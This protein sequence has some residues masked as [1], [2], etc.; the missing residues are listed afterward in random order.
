MSNFK[1]LFPKDKPVII[2]FPPFLQQQVFRWIKSHVASHTPR[3][4]VHNY[5]YTALKDSFNAQI[6]AEF[7]TD[8]GSTL[9][10]HFESISGNR[11]MIAEYINYLLQHYTDEQ[12][13]A[14]LERILAAANSEFSVNIRKIDLDRPHLSEPD[15]FI[16]P[17]YKIAT[18][19]EFRAEEETRKQ[20]DITNSE[21]LKDAWSDFYSVSN[22]N[23]N[24]VTQKSL[25]VVAGAIRD[26]L[27]SADQKTNLSDYARRIERDI[28]RLDL[29]N[30]E[31]VDWVSIIKSLANH[32]DARGVHNSG[33]DTDATEDQAYT[34]LHL[35]IAVVVMLKD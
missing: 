25:D 26:R 33:T 4:Q 10:E 15:P 21:R 34:V 3:P 7:Q 8:L 6:N 13:A 24:G 17:Q 27:Y 22:Q 16:P 28:E 11:E 9:E 23:L 29:P 31:K 12:S 32:V 1:R 30:K 14:S 2:G 35:S 20:L 18:S 5:L 19:L